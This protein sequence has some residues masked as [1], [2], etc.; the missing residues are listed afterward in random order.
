MSTMIVAVILAIAIPVRPG[1]VTPAPLPQPQNSQLLGTWQLVKV[2][3]AGA[4]DL[5]V[6][7]DEKRLQFTANEIQVIDKGMRQPMNDATYSVNWNAKPST[8]EIVSAQAEGGKKMQGIFKVDAD[9]LMICFAMEGP[10]PAS[11]DVKN[12]KVIVMLLKRVR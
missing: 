1:H 10:P 9:Q 3:V 4:P 2:S 11:F 7:V 6:P 8:I 12:D 5:P